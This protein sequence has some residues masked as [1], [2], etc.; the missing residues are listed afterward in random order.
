[1]C[2]LYGD[3]S[4]KGSA[5]HQYRLQ[6]CYGHRCLHGDGRCS[7]PVSAH[8]DYTYSSDEPWEHT[9]RLRL[10]QCSSVQH[11]CA[12]SVSAFALTQQDDALQR[13]QL[14]SAADEG[15]ASEE[16]RREHIGE[17]L[18]SFNLSSC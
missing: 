3:A 16:A 6:V 8:L 17:W 4:K 1:M 7:K 14:E 10:V 13:Q 11:C 9:C 12:T 5:A 2:L 18:Q 15:V